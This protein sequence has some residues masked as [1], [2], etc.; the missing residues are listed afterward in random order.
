MSQTKKGEDEF[1]PKEKS[2]LQKE[3]EVSDEN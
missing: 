2:T 1:P 3:K